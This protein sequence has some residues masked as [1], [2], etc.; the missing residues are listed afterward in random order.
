[1]SSESGSGPDEG[2]KLNLPKSDEF[3]RLLLGRRYDNLKQKERTDSN[4][5][6]E[7]YRREGQIVDSLYGSKQALIS[8]I[9]SDE[10]D[11]EKVLMTVWAEGKWQE[12]SPGDEFEFESGDALQEELG[13][14]SKEKFVV[15]TLYNSLIIIWTQKQVSRPREEDQ[16]VRSY[17]DSDWSPLFVRRRE[18]TLIEIR[19]PKRRRHQLNSEFSEE[20]AATK[21]LKERS[22]ESVLDDLST[23]FGEQLASLDLIEVRFRQSRLPN[24]SQLTL[25]NMSG[26]Q[27]D[28]QDETI[29]PKVIS[30]EIASKIAYLKFRDQNSGNIATIKVVRQTRGFSFEIQANYIDDEETEAIKSVVEDNFNISFDKVYPYHLQY[31][32][33]YILHQI[34]S[35]STEAYQTYYDDLKK[36]EKEIIDPY[37]NY[38]Q[39]DQF[40][41]WGCRTEY[42]EKPTECEECGNE[43][44]DSKSELSIDHELIY[45]DVVDSLADLGQT[46]ES[47]ELDVKI[48]GLQMKEVEIGSSDYIRA[49]FRRTQ[50]SGQGGLEATQD[51]RYEY[52]IY[53][54]SGHKPQRI[55]QYLLNTVFVTYGTAYEQ[56]LDNYGTVHLLELLRSKDPGQL[57]LEAIEKSH[58]GTQDRYRNR[59]KQA[60]RNLRQLQSKVDTGVINDYGSEDGPEDEFLDG[61]SAKKFEKDVFHLLKSIFNF[62][63]R[64]GRE[65]KKETDGCLVIP[66]GD[67]GYWVGGYDPKLT[68]DAKGYNIR[69]TEKDK[70]AYYILEESDREYI[71][72]VLKDG[73]PIDAHIFI[74]DI[75]R[76]GQFG[77]TADR[78]KDWF[79]LVKGEE[80]TLDVPIVFLRVEDLLGLYEIFDS[81]YTF[82]REYPGV[83]ATFREEVVNQLSAK[84]GHIEFDEESCDE[85]KKKLIQELDGRDKDRDIQEYTES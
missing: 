45:D 17:L 42:E 21:I 6:N 10:K 53:P 37:L 25:R 71:K 19:G 32:T 62:T 54:L 41:C 20:G 51:Y 73:D 50:N 11:P 78:V 61:Y 14:I 39:E 75:F 13:R 48:E 30:P 26:V 28:L 76:D 9:Q 1:M 81:N 36:K 64:W 3:W 38:T 46:V 15:D 65:G 68:T 60:V 67:E 4:L 56:E 80:S 35:G 83:M 63:E 84:S 44:F 52:F 74:S 5:L 7:I 85:I 70:V 43:S 69:S 47:E 59:A 23:I 66:K 33:D 29:N 16:T 34:L 8:E 82:L 58:R 22:E 18:S 40:V 72:D 55:G 77:P 2:S 49:L 57:L 27:E 31:Q 24:G 79:S 12:K